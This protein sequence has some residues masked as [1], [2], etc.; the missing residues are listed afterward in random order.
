MGGKLIEL[1]LQLREKTF[2]CGPPALAQGLA[3]S[4]AEKV[5]GK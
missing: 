5:T 2:Q 4:P 3:T 1:N